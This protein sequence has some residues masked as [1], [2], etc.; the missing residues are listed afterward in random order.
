MTS[1]IIGLPTRAE[2]QSRRPQMFPTLTDAQMAR[3][4]RV[5][6]ERVLAKGETL[7][8]QGQY[9]VPIHLILEGSIEI[10][11]PR[12]GVPSEESIVVQGP[13][14]FTG[15]INQL[16]QRRTL[17]RARAKEPTRVVE[18]SLAQLKTIVLTDSE[19]SEIFLRAFMLRRTGLLVGHQGDAI[20]LG[21]SHSAAT[22]RLQEFLTRNGHPYR[23]VDVDVDPS[24]QGLFDAFHVGVAD[25][26]VLIC[27]GDRV[28]KNPTNAEVADCLGLNAS[29][30][31]ASVRDLVVIGAG[32]AGLAAAVYAAS[33]GL[34]VLVIEASSP[35]GQA[36][37]SSKIENYLGFPTGISGNALSQRAL[38]QAEKFGAQLVVARVAVKL[39]CDEHPYR[40]ETE[41]GGSVRARAI[42]IATGAQ[43][44]K[45]EL[46]DLARFE[47]AGV[48][49]GAT[50]VEA[51]RCASEAVVIV[52]GGNSAGQAATFLSRSSAHVHILVRAEGLAASM[53][54]YLIR[55]IEET[56]NITLHSRTRVVGLSG[57]DR[58]ERVT[59]T[60]DAT[61]ETSTHPMGHVFSM[62]GAKPN[63]D[64]LG[65][66]L[67]LDDKGFVRTGL[68]IAAA[69]GIAGRGTARP[70][71][72][73]PTLHLETSMPRVF[74]VGD[75]RSGSVKRV[76]ASVGEGS[77]CI[78]LVHRVLAIE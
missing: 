15:E 20:V 55:R 17:V 66:C 19:L 50:F 25:V 51:Q 40:V 49:Y 33:E 3:I 10:L 18:V 34:D 1:P 22:L 71:G 41:D 78:Q 36:G 14:Q 56:P 21:S 8:E 62:T 37:S 76:A 77:A 60:D 54:R 63:T 12:D 32:P 72:A 5:G 31:R 64:W 57:G 59:W 52:G 6:K 44:R 67:A 9:G 13:G 53:S 11:H 73:R 46:P 38:A 75:V 28:L 58:L 45:L 43:Y 26:P 65:G 74:A 27:R 69:A 39:H 2:M 30:D 7:F 4:V 24:V 16:A 23:Y 68:D 61:G 29:I 35:G 47:G 70:L 42:V 48:Y